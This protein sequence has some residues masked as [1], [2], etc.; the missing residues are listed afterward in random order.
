MQSS[1]QQ[2]RGGQ[3]DPFE[4]MR[5]E[6]DRLFSHFA[7]VMGVPPLTGG[8]RPLQS[9]GGISSYQG[10]QSYI[11]VDV[12]E[13]NEAYQIIAEVPGLTE[14][15]IDITLSNDTLTIRGHKISQY[16]QQ[17]GQGGQGQGQGQGG[18]GQQ[19]GRQG[20]NYHLTERSY[21]EF[22]RTFQLPSNADGNNIRAEF[23][24]GELSLLIPKSAESQRQQKKIP[25]QTGSK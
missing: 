22:V 17:A 6:V 3:V 10:Q 23:R 8:R 15:D 5:H 7:S 12:I 21:G 4:Q 11:P 1:L 9:L 16:Q 13:T 20:V 2:Y 14:K 19:Q 18:Q 25:V 24:N